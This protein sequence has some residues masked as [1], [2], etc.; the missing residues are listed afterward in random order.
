MSVGTSEAPLFAFGGT[1]RRV[2]PRA[3][4]GL[5]WVVPLAVVTATIGVVSAAWACVPMAKLVSLQPD[6]SGPSGSRVVVNGLGFEPNS[7]EVRWNAADG[8][9]LGAARGPNFS[10][11]VTIPK[12]PEGLHTLIAVERQQDGSIGNTGSAP[13]DVTARGEAQSSPGLA[14]GRG[15][16]PGTESPPSSERSLDPPWVALAAAGIALLAIGALGGTLITRVRR[17]PT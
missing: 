15:D 1:V 13:F 11:T 6:S 2:S 9:R 16:G 17:R 3:R 8:P 5:R 4:R 12:A 7:V 14:T 10:V